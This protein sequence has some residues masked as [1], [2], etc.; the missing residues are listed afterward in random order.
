MVI[1]LAPLRQV[2]PDGTYAGF[3]AATADSPEGP[4]VV[5]TPSVN[6]T[7]QNDSIQAGDFQLF[8]DDDGT[9]GREDW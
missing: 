1:V 2:R 7:Y 3:A 6:V 4:F 9:G 8:V 5:Q